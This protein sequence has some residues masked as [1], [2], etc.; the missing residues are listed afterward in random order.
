MHPY[1]V[2]LKVFE[3]S[4]R[5]NPRIEKNTKA[6]IGVNSVQNLSKQISFESI[7]LKGEMKISEVS[8]IQLTKE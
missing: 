6:T 8:K 4:D 2:F 5:T 3:S 7:P 1:S